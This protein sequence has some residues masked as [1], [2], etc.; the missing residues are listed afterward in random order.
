MGR[1][2]EYRGEAKET[3]IRKKQRKRM[4]GGVHLK[5]R[6]TTEGGLNIWDT[7]KKKKNLLPLLRIGM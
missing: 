7:K 6:V 5:L 4:K 3:S 1:F 2:D